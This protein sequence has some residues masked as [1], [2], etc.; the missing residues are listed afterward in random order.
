MSCTIISLADM[1]ISNSIEYNSQE[2][3]IRSKL[4]KYSAEYLSNHSIGFLLYDKPEQQFLMRFSEGFLKFGV[5]NNKLYQVK[6]EQK[7]DK[8]R[9]AY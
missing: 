1:T 4:V 7:Q 8:I 6:R 9:F 2:R 3:N 5:V